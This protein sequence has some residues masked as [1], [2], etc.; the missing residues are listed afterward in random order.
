[1]RSSRLR[2]VNEMK[3]LPSH[4]TTVAM[5]AAL[6]RTLTGKSSDAMSHGMGPSEMAK[7]MTK[8]QTATTVTRSAAV[9]EPPE[10]SSDDAAMTDRLTAMPARPTYSNGLRPTRSESA[11]ANGISSIITT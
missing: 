2:K 6:P 4:P 10:E 11:P 8:A 9:M 3:R 1:M 7:K 5:D